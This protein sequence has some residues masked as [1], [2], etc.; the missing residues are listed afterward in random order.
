VLAPD[1]D[2]YR[3]V[4]SRAIVGAAL[5]TIEGDALPAEIRADYLDSYDG[6]RFVESMRYVRSYPTELP[7]LAQRLPG[8]DTPVQIIAGGRDRVV[9]LV[10]A[11]FLAER[12]PRSTLTMV[13]AGHFAWEEV[14]GEYASI[15][16]AWV[17]RGSS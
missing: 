16:T 14:P 1:L 3:A 6:E 13:D 9:P 5:D 12:L 15:I 11:E 8:I 2:R 4:D 17:D 10:N 7:K